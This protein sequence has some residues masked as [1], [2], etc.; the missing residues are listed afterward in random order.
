M[1]NRSQSDTFLYIPLFV[2]AGPNFGLVILNNILAGITNAT[3]SISNFLI[4]GPAIISLLWLSLALFGVER[5]KLY[6]YTIFF[7]CFFFAVPIGVLIPLEF[8]GIGYVWFSYVY[9]SLLG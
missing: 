2:G 9:L 3:E 8:A 4:G 7:M 6:L 5:R 1:S